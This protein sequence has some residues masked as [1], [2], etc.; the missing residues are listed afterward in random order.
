MSLSNDCNRLSFYPERSRNTPHL[1]KQLKPAR[2]GGPLN[3]KKIFPKKEHQ[4]IACGKLSLMS[5]P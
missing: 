4:V 3:L 2:E 1:S 5:W